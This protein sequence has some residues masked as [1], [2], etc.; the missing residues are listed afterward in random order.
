MI[1]GV[2]FELKFQFGYLLKNNTENIMKIFLKQ[3][4][5][6][7]LLSASMLLFAQDEL[8]KNWQKAGANPVA[9]LVG[10]DKNIAYTGAQSAFLTSIA[11]NIEHNDN[12]VL[13]QVM[14]LDAY[15]GKRIRFS[16][17]IKAQDVTGKSGLWLQ[18]SSEKNNEIVEF[19]N[20][21]HDPI[22]GTVNWTRRSIVIDISELGHFL[23]FGAYLEGAGKV[24]VDGI[25]IE[26]IERNTELARYNQR[27]IIQR[28]NYE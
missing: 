16:A 6:G 13:T 4:F 28:E 22:V 20:T 19:A 9:Y 5:L 24:W 1:F 8:P 15:R 2:K 25:S 12:V 27:N 17:F 11:D 3:C 10:I 23:Y 7:F 21:D 26:T 14:L 18:T